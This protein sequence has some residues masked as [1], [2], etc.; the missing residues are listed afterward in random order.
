M[1]RVLVGVVVLV[2]VT[3]LSCGGTALDPPT[4]GPTPAPAAAGVPPGSPAPAPPRSG[5]EAILVGAGDIAQCSL[6]GAIATGQLMTQL[7]RRSGTQGIT[8]GDNSNDDGSEENYRCFDKAW[9]SLKGSLFPTPGNHDYDLDPRDPYYFS[10][11]G[12]NAGPRGQGY[13]SYDH[14]DWHILS[15]NSELEE[16]RRPG[17]LA[18]MESDLNQ[19]PAPCTLAYFHRPL[20]SSGVFG[21]RRMKRL[22]DVLYAHGVDVI[23]NGHEHF[24]AAF[25]PLTPDGVPDARFGIRQIVAGTGGAR[26]FEVPAPQFGERI[27]GQTWGVI[28][29]TLGPEQYSWDFLSPTAAV[30][31]TGTGTCH[32]RPAQG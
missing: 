14:G 9:G 19:H 20:F 26:L 16:A 5:A 8:L 24:Y 1:Y 25:P 15:L 27:V 6:D 21:A 7:L 29:L 30:L 4:L 12:A 3:G 28:R 32:G 23:L 18:W 2:S 13:Y 31:D 11:F 17:Q 22:W 10:Y